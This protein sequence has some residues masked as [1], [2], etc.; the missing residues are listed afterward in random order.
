MNPHSERRCFI[1]RFSSPCKCSLC[2]HQTSDPE[3]QLPLEKKNELIHVLLRGKRGLLKAGVFV[4]LKEEGEE[5]QGVGWGGWE[6][7]GRGL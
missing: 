7:G 2:R 4:V 5:L 3:L 1:R 6:R